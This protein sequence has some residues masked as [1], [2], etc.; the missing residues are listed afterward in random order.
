MSQPIWIVTHAAYGDLAARPAAR[1]GRLVVV[2]DGLVEDLGDGPPCAGLV[3]QLGG[4]VHVVGAE[5]DVDVRRPLA[6]QVAVLLG[7]AARRPRSA[8]RAARP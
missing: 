8:A 5:H 2:G 6:D 7:Q 1:T 3:E 4:P